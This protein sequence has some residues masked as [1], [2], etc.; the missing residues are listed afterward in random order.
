M[1]LTFNTSIQPTR[2]SPSSKL[3]R[4]S[5]LVEPN[6]VGKEVMYSSKKLVELVLAHKEYKSYKIGIVGTGGVEK[7]TLAQK[8]YND[9]KIKGSFKMHAWICVS[10][11]GR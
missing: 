8:I 4:S 2:N 6:L 11:P 9:Q 7:T 5:N 1:F 10:A 3:I